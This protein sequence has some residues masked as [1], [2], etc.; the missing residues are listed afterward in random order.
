MAGCV[1]Q[2]ECARTHQRPGARQWGKGLVHMKETSDNTIVG[3]FDDY[4]T[5]E[6][7]ARELTNAGISRENIEVKSNFMTGAAGRSGRSGD[8]EGGVSGFFHRLF[9]G[10][11]E[12]DDRGHFAE[13]VRR[14]S[15][16]VCVTAPSSQ[17]DQAVDDHEP[18][19]RR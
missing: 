14:G 6:N 19:R 10:G 1:Q 3:V 8:D 13:A 2:P 16:V 7:V 18:T 12:T 5:A 11:D 15:A 9:G 4:S 17:L